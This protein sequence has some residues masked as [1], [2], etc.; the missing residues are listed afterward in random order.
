M[1]GLRFIALFVVILSF[2]A[3][4]GWAVDGEVLISQTTAEAGRVTPDDTAGFPVTISLPGSYKLSSNLNIPAGKIGILIA[5]NNVTLDL[6][7]FRIIGISSSGTETAISDNNQIRQNITVRNG[8]IVTIRTGINLAASRQCVI[9]GMRLNQIGDVAITVG[10]YSTVV[11]NSI[12]QVTGFAQAGGIGISGKQGQKIR[13]NTISQVLSPNGSFKPSGIKVL[14]NS[15][16]ENNTVML[17]GMGISTGLNSIVSSNTSSRNYIG[18]Q[19]DSS[20]T[21]SDNTASQNDFIGI[22]VKCPA[23]I[24]GNTAATNASLNFAVYGSKCNSFNNTPT[25]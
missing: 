17:S 2:L 8:S 18:I 5:T 21:V 15:L 14:H 9:E 19:T 11:D 1:K 3:E 6:N 12:N 13:G 25:P 20:S 16:V 22:S 7:G 23:S 4:Q 24:I 10:D